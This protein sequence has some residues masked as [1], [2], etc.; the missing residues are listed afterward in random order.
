MFDIL[1][2]LIPV[3]HPNSSDEYVFSKAK[4]LHKSD[5]YY[6]NNT[7]SYNA[8]ADNPPDLTDLFV[9]AGPGHKSDILVWAVA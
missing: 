6:F 7:D 3:G 9:F 8:L 4:E 2:E 1:E 5:I